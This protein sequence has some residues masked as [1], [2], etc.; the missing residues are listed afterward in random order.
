MVVSVPDPSLEDLL[1]GE[2]PFP[3][4]SSTETIPLLEDPVLTIAQWYFA[5]FLYVACSV[6]VY[7]KTEGVFV[8]SC[9]GCAWACCILPSQLTS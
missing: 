4:R 6:K 7:H 5:G 1:L 9:D 8:C 3:R 2:Y